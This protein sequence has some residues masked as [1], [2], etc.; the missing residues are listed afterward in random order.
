MAKIRERF[1]A[2]SCYWETRAP[3]PDALWWQTTSG[4]HPGAQ[5]V[6]DA[7]WPS[8]LDP[9]VDVNAY[10]PGIGQEITS[11]MSAHGRVVRLVH[12]VAVDDYPESI[13]G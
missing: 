13:F 7:N 8:E 2:V 12:G 5:H 3:H 1:E 6:F 11:V 9:E 10:R 4:W